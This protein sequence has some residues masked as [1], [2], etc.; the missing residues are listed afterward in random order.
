MCLEIVVSSIGKC[1]DLSPT[2]WKKV[3]EISGSFRI[4]WKS[5]FRDFDKSDFFRSESEHF[6]EKFPF[7]EEP[8]LE[9]LGIRSG[10]TEI[11]DLDL[12]EFSS[13]EDEVLRSD[14]IAKCFS[15]LRDTERDLLARTSCDIW[16]IYKDSLSGLRPKID[17]RSGIF[18]HS[19]M[20]REHEVESFNLSPVLRTTVRTSEI[21]E[22]IEA[23]E[24][25]E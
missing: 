11:F 13:T 1:R 14:L 4:V 20:G 17:K 3:F 23:I 15:T 9:E 7:V 8:R 24:I 25:L 18:R 10:L 22:S 6:R 2:K 21:S 5:F 16:E 12:L 19:L